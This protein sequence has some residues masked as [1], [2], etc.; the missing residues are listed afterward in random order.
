VLYLF[1]VAF[2]FNIHFFV[3]YCKP[4]PH[5]YSVIMVFFFT[6]ALSS[7]TTATTPNIVEKSKQQASRPVLWGRSELS[8]PLLTS[9]NARIAREE[10]KKLHNNNNNNNYNNNYNN[11]MEEAQRRLS[12]SSSSSSSTTSDTKIEDRDERKSRLSLADLTDRIIE[13][14]M[15]DKYLE[16]RQGYA[17]WRIGSPNGARGEIEQVTKEDLEADCEKQPT[18]VS[19]AQSR[20]SDSYTLAMKRRFSIAREEPQFAAFYPNYAT[21]LFKRRIAYWSSVSLAE[22]AI[23][24]IFSYTFACTQQREHFPD[25][26]IQVP[27]VVG[28]F[29]FIL[30]AYA[31][32]VQQINIRSHNN[33]K[34]DNNSCCAAA[35]SACPGAATVSHQDVNR[36][37]PFTSAGA[38]ASTAAASSS[39]SS[40][41][42]KSIEKSATEEDMDELLDVIVITWFVAPWKLSPCCGII[43]SQALLL[44]TIFFAFGIIGT[45]DALGLGT[46]WLLSESFI[47]I[48]CSMG[49][50]CFI[51]YAVC[52][53]IE[54]HHA[55]VM[56][57]RVAAWVDLVSSVLFALGSTIPIIHP[58]DK[59]ILFYGCNLP[60]LLGS[61]GFFIASIIQLMFWRN[62]MPGMVLSRALNE[63][64]KGAIQQD[65]TRLSNNTIFINIV[66]IICAG[67]CSTN[68]CMMVNLVPFA[69]SVSEFTS[70]IFILIFVHLLLYVTSYVNGL[71]KKE[72]FRSFMLAIRFLS[73]LLIIYEVTDFTTLLVE[74]QNNRIE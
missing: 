45:L 53:V 70:A 7:E 19:N 29:W 47:W 64:T 9:D 52:A 31:G 12:L 27:A 28:A 55:E 4:T 59:N 18:H 56:L 3:L 16:W 57:A 41:K 2:F 33:D 50:I 5:S 24:Y 71:P 67:L 22:G 1:V 48:P 8:D 40:N 37:K 14:G 30:C 61:I 36:P 20:F 63:V 44:G 66:Y 42:K 68:A 38:G 43:G 21:F 51:I 15:Y 54:N 46:S 34:S 60:F 11:Y 13:A 6:D 65:S 49:G 26:I 32:Y 23:L 17:R 39:S 74:S 10:S 72:P 35:T 69:R 58:F 62:D 25:P 73:L